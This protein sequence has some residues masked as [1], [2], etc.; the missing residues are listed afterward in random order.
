MLLGKLSA[1]VEIRTFGLLL[2]YRVGSLKSFPRFSRPKC[3][4]V[5][6]SEIQFLHIINRQQLYLDH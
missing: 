6:F 1:L 3:D 5:E 4:A 2:F